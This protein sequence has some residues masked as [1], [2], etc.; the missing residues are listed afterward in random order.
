MTKYIERNI[1]EYKS[2][3]RLPAFEAT[4]LGCGITVRAYDIVGSA[5]MLGAYTRVWM[6]THRDCK[7]KAE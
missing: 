4:C 3:Q 6:D 7:G 2:E 1:I 5:Q